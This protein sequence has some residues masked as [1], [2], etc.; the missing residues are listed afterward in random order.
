MLLS[1]I[2]FF[3]HFHPLLVHLPVGILLVG[4]VLQ[5]MAKKRR[6]A[7]LAPAVP[8]V[9]LMGCCTAFLSCITGYLLS[10]SDTYDAAT[11][12]WHMW[13]AIGLTLLSF[14]LYAKEKNPAFAISKN[15]L[16]ITVFFLLM[17]TGHLGGSLTHGPDYLSKPLKDIFPSDSLAGTSTK[18]IANVQEALVFTDIVSPVLQSKCYSCHNA[19]KQKGGLRMDE[20]GLL[21][22]GGKDGKMITPG[23]AGESGL[24]K[25]LLL[26]ADD[27]HHMPPKEKPQ[28][29]E[30]QVNMLTWWI[31]N[32]ADTQ[33]KVKD[34]TQTEKIK[35]YLASLQTTVPEKKERND[36]PLKPV[37]KVDEKTTAQLRAKNITV[38][39]VAQNTNYVQANF[40]NYSTITQTDLQL[41]YNLHQQLIW[42]N[43][44][45][46]VTDDGLITGVQ[47]L[48]NLTR[49]DL[50]NTPIT[51]KSIPSLLTLVNLQYLN[52]SG[53]KISGKGLLLL[54]NLSKLQS[55]YLYNTHTDNS[56]RVALQKL[57]PHAIVDTGGYQ[58]PLLKE[59][60]TIIK[61]AAKKP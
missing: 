38:M 48:T 34:F 2:E 53:T 55:L 28:L 40:F 23:N 8:V 1:V 7:I 25:R 5:W 39:P 6:F 35:P 60:T 49:L 61:V 37:D 56:E 33:K 27:D 21:M 9:L 4:L 52:L 18:P 29:T 3:G 26:P 44:A 57:L 15:L 54:K 32:N 16:S 58:V 30:G 14:V 43:L 50:T 12:S 10:I 41:L 45:N 36:I 46:T 11:V 13:M 59:D 47:K 22:K 20:I 19:N 24:I 17:F 31:N 51:D 42:L